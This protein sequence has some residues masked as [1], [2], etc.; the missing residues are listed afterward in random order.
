MLYLYQYSSQSNNK[1]NINTT[2]FKLIIT[3]L[4]LIMV[5]KPTRADNADATAY[6]FNFD[7]FLTWTGHTASSAVSHGVYLQEFSTNKWGVVLKSESQANRTITYNN[8]LSLN[9]VY[10]LTF[11]ARIDSYAAGVNDSYPLRVSVKNGSYAVTIYFREDGIYYDSDN[12]IVRLTDAA[13][14]GTWHNYHVEYN[15]SEAKLFIDNGSPLAFTGLPQN[16]TASSIQLSARGD[17]FTTSQSTVD[18][19]RLAPERALLTETW[20]SLNDWTAAGTGY[21]FSAVTSG[22]TSYLNVTRGGTDRI[23]SNNT[24]TNVAGKYTLGIGLRITDWGT[25]TEVMNIGVNSGS[26]L[27]Q[28]QINQDR[29]LM[30]R[31]SGDSFVQT[32][33]QRRVAKNESFRLELRVI[34]EHAELWELSK[35]ADVLLHAWQIPG[36]TDPAKISLNAADAVTKGGSFQVLYVNYTDEVL[37]DEAP[38][39]GVGAR[40]NFVNGES[41]GVSH[42]GGGYGSNL[43]L[44]STGNNILGAGFGAGWVSALRSNMHST[45]D[46]NPT[47]AGA[48]DHMGA[49]TTLTKST[50][51]LGGDVI[52]IAPVATPLFMLETQTYD[53]QQN[54]PIKNTDGTTFGDKVFNDGGNSDEDGLDETHLQPEDELRSEMN[55][56]G[57]WEDVTGMTTTG[58]SILRHYARWEYKR[59]P[60]AILQF[61]AANNGIDE[62]WRVDDLSPLSYEGTQTPSNIDLSFLLNTYSI[63]LLKDQ[64]YKYF[65]WKENGVWQS[66]LAQNNVFYHLGVVGTDTETDPAMNAEA[67][68]DVP[69]KLANLGV[70]A[71]GNVMIISKSAGANSADAIGLYFPWDSDVNY[72]EVMGLARDG[73]SNTPLFSENRNINSYYSVSLRTNK[74]MTI[75][76]RMWH[77]GLRA[78]DHDDANVYETLQNEYYH[79]IGTPNEIFS[80]AE[81]LKLAL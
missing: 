17:R 64:G 37:V 39:Y 58:N 65:M 34:E 43:K 52:T 63:R 14:E 3:L 11:K 36:N 80:T 41:F 19:L 50:N 26:H 20:S 42:F 55:F 23:L 75:F 67:R 30:V 66:V 8:Q 32:N 21:T 69:V 10:E 73:S 57:L 46:Y 5:V 54:E 2:T 13:V 16:T 49:P 51:S 56:T 60:D 25:D 76:L 1:K 78:P 40:I 53:W 24:I 18:N 48:A 44:T 15:D 35:Q 62:T 29:Y 4:L 79:I 74:W 31:N 71:D 22:A 6:N 70:N 9:N 7:E 47:Q 38:P 81:E 61:N 45:G 28:L 77:L 68:G 33:T 12:G 27:A 59:N 72:S